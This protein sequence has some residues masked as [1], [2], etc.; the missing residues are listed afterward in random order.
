LDSYDAERRPV[1]AST[2]HDFI[3]RSI[4]ED[5]AFLRANDPDGDPDAFAAALEM[6]SAA[7]RTEVGAFAPH[8]EGS[9]IIGGAG[10]PSAVGR[11]DFAARAG[12]HLAPLPLEDG[13]HTFDALSDGF[14]LLATPGAETAAITAAAVARRLPLKVVPMAADIA[15]RYGAPL[16][17]VRPD[18]FV[19]WL[20]TSG[21]A[22]AILDRATGH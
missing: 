22:P 6:R 21:D 7:A 15:A 2:A 19:A 20:G 1:F 13:R 9:P 5:R 17:L 11:H 4:E 10:T 8:Y 3:A 16:V 12:H 14:T 18:A